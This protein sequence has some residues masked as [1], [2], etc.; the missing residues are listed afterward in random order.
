M[1]ITHGKPTDEHGIKIHDIERIWQPTLPDGWAI[2]CEPDDDINVIW[3]SDDYFFSTFENYAFV[4]YDKTNSSNY[5]TI[6]VYPEHQYISKCAYYNARYEN[7]VLQNGDRTVTV[8][9]RPYEADDKY[10]YRLFIT[11]GEYFVIVTIERIDRLTNEE[12]LKF[13]VKEYIKAPADTQ[14]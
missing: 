14:N 8:Q 11:N 7:T 2:A 1:Q 6:T 3:R 4:G 5:A 13:G 9:E 12:L 10:L